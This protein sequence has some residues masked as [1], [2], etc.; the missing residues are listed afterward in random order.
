VTGPALER[1]VFDCVENPA[2]RSQLLGRNGANVLQF[3]KRGTPKRLA[4]EDR[5][6]LARYFGVEEAVLGATEAGGPPKMTVVPVIDVRA[7]A[8]HGAAATR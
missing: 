4:E 8:G 1:L 2:I 5:R 6:T 3:I 7:S